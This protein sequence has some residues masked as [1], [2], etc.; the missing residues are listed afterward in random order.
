V[1]PR[2]TVQV[3]VA[4]AGARQDGAR[5]DGVDPDSGSQVDGEYLGHR[6]KRSL[7]EPIREVVGFRA[8][9]PGVE[10]I[11]DRGVSI[12]GHSGCEL[13][14]EEKGCSEIDPELD[15]PVFEVRARKVRIEKD[16]SIVD[17][18]IET[19]KVFSSG[20]NQLSG[21]GG[22]CEVRLMQENSSAECLDVFCRRLCVVFRA[23]VVENDV[24]AFPG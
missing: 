7:A 21:F 15:T 13:L 4:L 12:C 8:R 14:G 1:V 22:I 9:D 17:E 23:P 16:R 3:S 24:A 19:S 6:G 11:D 18:N 2:E 10:D 20:P 5:C